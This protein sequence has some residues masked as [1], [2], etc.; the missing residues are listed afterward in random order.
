M[1]ADKEFIF[2]VNNLTSSRVTP[3]LL[4]WISGFRD[5]LP[6]TIRNSEIGL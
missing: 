5:K 1:V 4:V 3:F 6:E 2:T